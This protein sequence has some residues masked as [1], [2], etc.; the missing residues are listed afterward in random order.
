VC[1]VPTQC[2]NSPPDGTGLGAAFPLI[3]RL[4]TGDLG[5]MGAKIEWRLVWGPAL[6]GEIIADWLGQL[7]PGGSF[8]SV[9]GGAKPPSDPSWRDDGRYL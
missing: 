5:L 8:S 1:A 9:W 7:K 4:F 3:S 2:C 6:V